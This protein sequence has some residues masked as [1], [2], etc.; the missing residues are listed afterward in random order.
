MNKIEKALPFVVF[1][2]EVD[3]AF[4]KFWIAILRERL[5]DSGLETIRKF[6]S[7]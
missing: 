7:S 6:S 3:R 4:L 5:R 2:G 1:D